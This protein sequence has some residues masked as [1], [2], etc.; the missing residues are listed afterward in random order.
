[1]GDR[2]ACQE[3]RYFTQSG[4]GRRIR[5]NGDPLKGQPSK[6]EIPLNGPRIAQLDCAMKL[7][8][9]ICSLNLGAGNRDVGNPG[10][11]NDNTGGA[12]AGVPPPPACLTRERLA[13]AFALMEKILVDRMCQEDVAW[14][15]I[16]EDRIVWRELIELE[17]QE[18]DERIER[19][20]AATGLGWQP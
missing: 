14:G 20:A 7:N 16:I 12:P 19:I 15:R 3:L 10:T 18:V 11:G 9:H 2:S 17:L 1:M 6:M 5:L 8:R 4:C 13:D